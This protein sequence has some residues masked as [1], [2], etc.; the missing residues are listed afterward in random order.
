MGKGC[1]TLGCGGDPNF[2]APGRGHVEGCTHPVHNYLKGYSDET[3]IHRS[4]R[5]AGTPVRP[6]LSAE[7]GALE[8]RN[9]DNSSGE[10][11]L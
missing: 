11:S 1:P 6:D 5:V 10:V 2:A 9:S 8:Q 4:E 7:R 3:S